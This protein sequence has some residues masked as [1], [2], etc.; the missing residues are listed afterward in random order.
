M[1][2]VIVSVQVIKRMIQ[3]VLCDKF[4]MAKIDAHVNI[5]LEYWHVDKINVLCSVLLTYISLNVFYCISMSENN[6]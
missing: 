4:L 6:E 3:I 1:H 5:G 2:I